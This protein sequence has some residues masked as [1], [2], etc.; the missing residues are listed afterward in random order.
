MLLLFLFLLC[1]SITSLRTNMIKYSPLSHLSALM[2]IFPSPHSRLVVQEGFN[3]ME[4]RRES[5]AWMLLPPAPRGLHLHQSAD[6]FW[7]L[8]P[9]HLSAGCLLRV[10]IYLCFNSHKGKQFGFICGCP[11]SWQRHDQKTQHL[12]RVTGLDTNS[13]WSLQY[14]VWRLQVSIKRSLHLASQHQSNRNTWKRCLMGQTEALTVIY[15]TQSAPHTL[16]KDARQHSDVTLWFAK[17][18]WEYLSCTHVGFFL[19]PEGTIS[20]K[21]CRLL[22]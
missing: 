19:K 20:R 3:V 6:A 9:F 4:R 5:G 8:L 7:E 21:E 12:K 16:F 22:S 11:A 18:Q 15:K 10:I 17:L 2:N 13:S 1:S 14:R